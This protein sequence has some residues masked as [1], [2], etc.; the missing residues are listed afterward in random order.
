MQSVGPL[1]VAQ[2]L[3]RRLAGPFAARFILQ[4]LVAI[5][6][7]IRDGVTDAKLGKSPFVVALLF[8]REGAIPRRELLKTSLRRIFM[9]LAIGVVLDMIVQWYL[10]HRVLLSGAIL[11]GALLVALPY[12]IARGLTNRIVTNRNKRRESR[13]EAGK[14]RRVA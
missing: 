11:V 14:P 3:A 9:P 2:G 5:F 6:L 4:P 13:A 12:T 7:G 1:S 8:A 10:F